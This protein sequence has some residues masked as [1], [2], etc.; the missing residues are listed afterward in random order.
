MVQVTCSS[1][2]MVYDRVKVQSQGVWLQSPQVNSI[3]STQ[4][5]PVSKA[6]AK[7]V[8]YLLLPHCCNS[9]CDQSE[10]DCYKEEKKVSDET[11]FWDCISIRQT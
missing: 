9:S 7:L 5:P 11:L 10:I 6:S 4:H 8:F 2:V 3:V 1:Q